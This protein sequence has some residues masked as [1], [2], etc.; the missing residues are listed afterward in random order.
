M[1]NQEIEFEIK[2]QLGLALSALPTGTAQLDV[3]REKDKRKTG[4]RHKARKTQDTQKGIEEQT[5]QKKS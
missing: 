4:E 2:K 3:G 5:R 1:D